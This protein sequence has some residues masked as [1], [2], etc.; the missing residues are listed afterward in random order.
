M[1]KVVGKVKWLCVVSK[2]FKAG[3]DGVTSTQKPLS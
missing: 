3:N 1:S 2:V